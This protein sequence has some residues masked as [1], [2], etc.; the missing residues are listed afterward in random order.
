M[1]ISITDDIVQY[2]YVKSGQVRRLLRIIV[3]LLCI[4]FTNFIFIVTIKFKYFIVFL[5]VYIFEFCTT[6]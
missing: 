5:Y 2:E 4:L 1:D 3:T 6:P